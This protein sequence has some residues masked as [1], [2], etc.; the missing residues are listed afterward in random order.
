MIFLYDSFLE[1]SKF[2]SRYFITFLVLFRSSA[3]ISNAQE[4]PDKL[5]IS[6]VAAVHLLT[7]DRR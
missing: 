3:W 2:E 1:T 6:S 5:P 4:S 7:N